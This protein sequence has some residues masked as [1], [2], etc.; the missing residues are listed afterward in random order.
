MVVNFFLFRVL[1]GDPAKTFAPRGRNADAER[2]AQ[3]RRD[4]GTDRPWYEQFWSYLT[5]LARFDLGES[6]SLKQ[7]VAGVIAVHCLMAAN[8]RP[9]FPGLR[10]GSTYTAIMFGLFAVESFMLMQ[11]VQQRSYRPWDDWGERDPNVWR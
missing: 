4:F 3:I 9:L 2:L 8:G 10:I 6:W 5:G 1:P 7:S 11:Q